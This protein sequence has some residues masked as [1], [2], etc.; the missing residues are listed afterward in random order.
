MLFIKFRWNARSRHSGDGDVWDWS[1]TSAVSRQ[2]RPA[3]E[4]HH[5]Q[6]PGPDV[7]LNQHIG[8]RR[9]ELRNCGKKLM[10]DVRWAIRQTVGI[11]W[12]T[13][14]AT[15]IFSSAK[16]S[17]SNGNFSRSSKE[18]NTATIQSKCRGEVQE[19]SEKCRNNLNY[20]NPFSAGNVFRHPSPTSIDVRF[21]RLK[22]IPHWKK[23]NEGIIAVDL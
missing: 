3:T 10:Q 6:I 7:P 15:H 17:T 19:E 5:H 23:T 14:T 8:P 2:R 20:F 16:A 9:R 12:I 13:L 1:P 4:A 11:I 22:N 21:W 18:K